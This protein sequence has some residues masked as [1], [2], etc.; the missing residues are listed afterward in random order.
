[1]QADK[2]FYRVGNEVIGNVLLEHIL[3]FP[4]CA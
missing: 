2:I 4:E 1:M 3:K